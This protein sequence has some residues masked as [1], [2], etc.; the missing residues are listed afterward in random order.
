MEQV[1]IG[2]TQNPDVFGAIMGDDYITLN[3]D[4][5]M[6][7]KAQTLDMVRNH[8]LPK[9]DAMQ[10]SRQTQRV[11]GTVAIRTGQAKVYKAGLLLADFIYTQTWV[12][13]NNRWQFIGWQGTMTGW[14]KH[15]PVLLTLVVA[16]LTMFGLWRRISRRKKAV[17]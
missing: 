13:R 3:A 17:G 2:A 1:M 4:G 15:Y 8:P 11:Y 5:V 6:E 7:N 16:G 14:P 9:A 12:Y 10:V